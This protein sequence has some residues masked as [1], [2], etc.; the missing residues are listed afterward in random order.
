M[1]TT[2]HYDV[3][4]VTRD[5]PPEVIRAA[6]KALSQKW[7]PDRNSSPDAAAMMQ[8]INAAYAVLSNPVERA[9]YD[10][11]PEPECAAP[12]EQSSYTRAPRPEHERPAP[13]PE[14]RRGTAFE[15]DEEKLK[16]GR[17]IVPSEKPH[18]LFYI[19]FPLLAPIDMW[20]RKRLK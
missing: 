15:I 18:W 5:A 1:K 3:L 7:H 8:A 12:R 20:L 19:F 10:R 13:R 17:V 9:R 14:R 6:Y 2:T 11:A 4:R 16:A